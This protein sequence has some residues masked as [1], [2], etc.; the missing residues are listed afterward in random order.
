MINQEDSPQTPLQQKLAQTGKYLGI[1]ALI[2]CLVI[3]LLGL[4]E[5]VPPLE[6]FMISISLAVA[7]IPEGLPAVVTIVLAIGVRR[8]A[9]NRAIIRKLLRWKPW[10]RQRDL[11][12]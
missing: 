5:S 2:I 9:A 7:A 4:M 8:L 1:G 10:Q 12:G 6:M 3:F 11:L